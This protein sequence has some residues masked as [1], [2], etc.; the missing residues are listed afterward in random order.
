MIPSTNSKLHVMLD[1]NVFMSQSRFI[2]SKV[3][4]V[5]KDPSH[6]ALNIR[7][8][9]PEMAQLEREY[10]FRQKLKHVLAAAKEMPAFFVNTWVGDAEAL[11][12]EIAR[13][14]QSE[15]DELGIAVRQCDPARVD[16]RKIMSSAGSRLPPFDPNPENEKGFKDAIVAETF[17]QLCGDLP[18]YGAE[19]AILVTDD[20][21]LA[22]HVAS[23]NYPNGK[24]I[25]GL[26]ALQSELNFLV[27][28]IQPVMF[29]DL[30]E[31]ANA[32]IAT[33]DEFWSNVA[34][35]ARPWVDLSA[36]ND[37]GFS[38]QIS[39][40]LYWPPVFLRK[41]MA[42]VL[43]S[44][45]YSV[46]RTAQ[47]WVSDQH[48]VSQPAAPGLFG[49]SAPAGPATV[50]APF[51][52]HDWHSGHDFDSIRHYGSHTVGIAPPPIFPAY[53]G[54]LETLALP[55][56]NFNVTW[57]AD[58]AVDAA[59]NGATMLSNPRIILFEPATA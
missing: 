34:A 26:D 24:V 6:A 37:I 1:T 58:Y 41:E 7:W 56:V 50:T 49:L 45:V 18:A 4:K 43:F 38:S 32:L 31:K 39:G 52:F 22:S 3:S 47:R 35:L 28:D 29:E 55:P 12:K 42:R 40:A 33:A 16:W 27:S 10:Q 30:Q 48:V 46:Q 44:C 20:G 17:E 54:H 25:R 9:I 8:V 5:I 15:L 51:G 11:Y 19:S 23:R 59:A 13:V 36:A 14:G 53:A 2:A 57:S 21:L